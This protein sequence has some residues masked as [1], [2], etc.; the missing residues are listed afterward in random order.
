M[1][2]FLRKTLK[3]PTYSIKDINYYI[4]QINYYITQIKNL[5]QQ[6]NIH[7]KTEIEKKMISIELL[8]SVITS[9]NNY[10][11]GIITYKRIGNITSHISSSYIQLSKKRTRRSS[12]KETP[13]LIISMIIIEDK[14]YKGIG[15]GNFLL[16]YSIYLCSLY[17]SK[18]K[19]ATLD[20]DSNRST[21]IEHNIYTKIG[22]DYSS[23]ISLSNL[24]RN[25]LII[26]GPE[27][28]INIDDFIT[29]NKPIHILSIVFNKIKRKFSLSEKIKRFSRK[30]HSI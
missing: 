7:V 4:T 3:S 23:P 24:E 15:L 22:F 18:I 21:N 27:R 13:T 14:E 12:N 25:Q 26:S 19:Y 17:H 2:A 11:S 30:I 29:S 5:L 10:S 20:D 1:S 6:K 16:V 8:K 9:E 28:S